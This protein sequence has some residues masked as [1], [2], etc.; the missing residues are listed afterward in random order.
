MPSS[1]APASRP[2]DEVDVALDQE[3]ILNKTGSTDGFGD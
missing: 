3:V 1:K 2:L